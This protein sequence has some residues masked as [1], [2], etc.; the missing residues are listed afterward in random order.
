MPFLYLGQS[1]GAT[2]TIRYANFYIFYMTTLVFMRHGETE[3]N[4]MGRQSSR[5]D[6]SINERGAADVRAVAPAL[7]S[8]ASALFV[9][10]PLNRAQE[11]A[12]IVAAVLGIENAQTW[13]SLREI[14]VGV[15]EGETH[16]SA[17]QGPYAKDYLD[18][19]DS[20]SGNVGAP[21]GETWSE[22]DERARNV[23]ESLEKQDR[24]ALVIGHGCFIRAILA[25][26]IIGLPS[27][28]L[29]RFRLDNA[30]FIVLSKTSSNW[31]VAGC[32][33]R[34]IPQLPLTF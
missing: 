4:R 1:F 27:Q 3:W 29:R 23:L 12:S 19:R 16:T 6:I 28:N 11:T 33:V 32:N 13:E 2:D 21:L 25:H 17:L 10:S 24:D 7:E 15:F 5:T 9:S 30:S 22:V 18:W 8:F 20:L 14:D 34:A 31:T 26:A